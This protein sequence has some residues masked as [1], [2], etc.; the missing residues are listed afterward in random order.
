MARRKQK[1]PD[2]VVH[3]QVKPGE[4]VVYQDHAY[5]D[6]ATLQVRRGDL[7]EVEGKYVEVDPAQVPDVAGV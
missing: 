1:N 4:V 6:R 2:E 3:L 7:N 5:G